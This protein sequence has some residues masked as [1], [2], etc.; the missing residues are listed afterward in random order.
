MVLLFTEMVELKTSFE[1]NVKCQWSGTHAITFHTPSTTSNEP[2]HDKTNKMACAHS[3]DLDQPGHSLSLIRVFAVRIK[4]HW[5][6]N[7]LLNAQG[8]LWSDWADAQDDLSLSWA[9][10][11][12]C[13]LCQAVAQIETLRNGTEHDACLFGE[14]REQIFPSKTATKLTSNEHA[15]IS[16]TKF[17]ENKTGQRAIIHKRSTALERSVKD[18]RRRGGGLNLFLRVL[19]PRLSF[20]LVHVHCTHYKDINSAWRLTNSS[21][22]HHKN[23]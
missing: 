14:Q 21:M 19:T 3:E 7:Y 11:S 18:Y 5:A 20:A 8:R 4:K 12:F 6:L 9:H 17:K 15:Q 16:W 2:Q 13:W 10:R 23:I 1:V 22:K